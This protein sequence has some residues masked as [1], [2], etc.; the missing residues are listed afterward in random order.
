[1]L[2]GH[3]LG[4]AWADGSLTYLLIHSTFYLLGGWLLFKSCERYARRRGS[5]GQY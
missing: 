4:T 5:L 1:M 3:S 2:S